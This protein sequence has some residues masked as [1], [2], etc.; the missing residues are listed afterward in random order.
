M[1]GNYEMGISVKARKERQPLPKCDYFT[2][3]EVSTILGVSMRWIYDRV[4]TNEAPPAKRFGLLIKFPKDKFNA[5]RQE[6]D[7]IQCSA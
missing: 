2:V 7:D 3:K 4:G 1:A 5:W 6:R